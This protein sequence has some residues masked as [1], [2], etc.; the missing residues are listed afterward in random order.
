MKANLSKKIEL[1]ANILI[2]VVALLLGYVL[3]KRY[4]FPPPVGNGE[5]IKLGTKVSLPDVEWSHGDRNLVMVLQKGCHF[6][7]ESVPFYQRL[8]RE[9][10]G[11]GDVQVVA[12]LPQDV[13]E[14]VQYLKDLG[15]SVA[16]VRQASPASLGALGTPTLLLVDHTGAI[17]GAWVG[18][19]SP[20]KESEVLH[21]LLAN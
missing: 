10:S 12:A 3:V 7:S 8:A 18:K 19:L 1:L 5:E 20:D 4:V 21:R 16:Q 2:I 17:T 9:T 15:V 14:G 11:R 6:C 13:K